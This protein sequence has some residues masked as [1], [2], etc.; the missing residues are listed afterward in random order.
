MDTKER[1]PQYIQLVT[2]PRAML[3]FKLV[4]E[5]DQSGRKDDNRRLIV[6]SGIANNTG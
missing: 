6:N 5:I 2:D 4:G 3:T 1:S